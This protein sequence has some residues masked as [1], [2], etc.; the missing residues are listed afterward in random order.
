MPTKPAD[1]ST[2]KIITDLAPDASTGGSYIWSK[3]FGAAGIYETGISVTV[4]GTGNVYLS[5]SLQGTGTVDFG[6]GAQTIGASDGGFIASYTA[7][8]TYRWFKKLPVGPRMAV[9]A[10]G[11]VYITGTFMGTA[12]FGGGP[13]TT[14]D[15]KA[16]SAYVASFSPTGSHL[17][18]KK[19][20]DSAPP[21]NPIT[22]DGIAVTANGDVYITGSFPGTIDFGGGTLPA[23]GS[24]D[25]FVASLTSSGGH[26]WS[27]HFGSAPAQSKGLGVA[28]DGSGNAY[29]TGL[30]M[31]SVDF[32]GGTLA[33]TGSNGDLFLASFTSSGGYRWSSSFAGTLTPGAIA[34]AGTGET[35]LVGSALGIVNLGGSALA[36]AGGEDVFVASYSTTGTHR[37]SK[38]FGDFDQQVGVGV[39]CNASS[40]YITGYFRGAVDFGG[41][42]LLAIGAN[43]KE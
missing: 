38:R 36:P 31:G 6:G 35:Y 17:W 29:V 34:A 37:W 2:D 12:D 24:A 40:A 16:S 8:G 23:T 26:R 19:Y 18:S 15:S 43:Q 10:A 41:G 20:G 21:A 30:F 3:G 33:A 39:A 13:L 27:K 14:S 5:G 1:K 4:D 42:P 22:S 9:D 7:T 25:I 28:M 11:N 32:G